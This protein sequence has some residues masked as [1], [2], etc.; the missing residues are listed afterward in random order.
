MTSILKR[1]QQEDERIKSLTELVKREGNYQDYILKNDLLC[2]M[3]QGEELIVA[4]KSM[5]FEILRIAHSNGHFK[6][7]K[8]EELINKEFF[9]PNVEEKIDKFV[10]NCITCILS[11]RKSGKPEGFLHPINKEDKP[12]S[13]FHM[14]H[15]GPMP[16]TPINFKHILT[17]IDAFTKFA[18]IFPVKSTTEETLKKLKLLTG[19]FEN[20]WRIIA[21]RGTVFTSSAF[22]EFC[23]DENIELVHTTTGVPR[24]NGQVGRIHR[25][26]IP[27]LTQLSIEDPEKWY[28]HVRSIQIFIN[29]TYSRAIGVSPGE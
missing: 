18:W 20:P 8:M 14:D 1:N 22:Q 7:K 19:I 15:L 28:E 9:I 26:I 21:D 10:R 29:K 4:P 12:L 5:Y 23:T 13:T 17:I 24:G 25:T 27:A 2:R 16:S 11:E 6:S 3:I